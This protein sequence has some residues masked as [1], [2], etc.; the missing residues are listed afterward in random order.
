MTFLLWYSTNLSTLL[1]NK[2]NWLITKCFE[3]DL[4][5]LGSW[6][7]CLFPV[8]IIH[9]YFPGPVGCFNSMCHFKLVGDL[10]DIGTYFQTQQAPFAQKYENFSGGICSDL[11]I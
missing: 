2:G 9:P 11:F 6:F 4:A 3:F 8:I 5:P 1:G 7:Y 10:A